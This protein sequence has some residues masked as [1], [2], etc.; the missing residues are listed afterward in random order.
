MSTPTRT[1]GSTMRP[2]MTQLGFEYLPPPPRLRA[3]Y[4]LREGTFAEPHGNGQEAPKADFGLAPLNLVTML[5]QRRFATSARDL[6]RQ[7]FLREGLTL[8]LW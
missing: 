7:A 3:R 2:R 6:V 5:R 1:G 4:R 8:A